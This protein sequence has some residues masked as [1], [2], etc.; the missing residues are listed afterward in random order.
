MLTAPISNLSAL[1]EI[2]ESLLGSVCAIKEQ[3]QE[4]EDKVVD[5]HDLIEAEETLAVF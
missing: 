3:L 4:I 5:L 2:H 1:K